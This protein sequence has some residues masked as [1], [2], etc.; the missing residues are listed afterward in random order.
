[1]TYKGLYDDV[2]V[3]SVILVNDGKMELTVIKK[4]QHILSCL[5]KN[6]ATVK[7]TR[8]IN[9]PNV[10]LNMP[11][12]SEKDHSAVADGELIQKEVKK[13]IKIVD[14]K[15]VETETITITK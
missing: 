4:S 3:G 7:D 11:Y 1:M 9:V 5:V 13:E 14:G 8:G 2:Q 12:I 15:T 6:D 10:R